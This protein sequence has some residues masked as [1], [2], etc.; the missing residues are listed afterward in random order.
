MPVSIVCE[1]CG[2]SFNVPPGRAKTAKTCSTACAGVRQAKAYAVERA[3]LMCVWC[4]KEFAAPKCHAHR[5]KHCSKECADAAITG[6]KAPRVADGAEWAH[7]DGYVLEVAREHPY[8]VG[9]SVL[10]HRLVV[11][12]WMREA[13]PMHA[14]LIE[15]DGVKYLRREIAV[16]HRNE[17]KRDNRRENLMAC[18]N[19]AH[20]DIHSGRTPMRGTVWPETGNEILAEDRTVERKCEQ[21][22]APFHKKRS[23]VARGSGRFCSR[24]CYG[25]SRYQGEMPAFVQRK[26][27]VCGKEFAVKRGK[28]LSGVG[29]YCSNA[30]RYV[31]QRGIPP[32]AKR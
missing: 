14:F 1:V 15:I 32:S 23:D 17:D 22:G 2:K 13:A 11:E 8:A 21:C 4:G 10:Q 30:C 25:E 20:R 18:T 12:R 28:V 29:K 27:L 3:K 5:R 26:C 9:D 16:H 19:A 24:A 6:V 31:A 7:A